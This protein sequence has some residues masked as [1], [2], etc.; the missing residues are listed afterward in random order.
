MTKSHNEV[1]KILKEKGFNLNEQDIETIRSEYP[2]FSLEELE[3]IGY[4]EEIIAQIQIIPK[5][6]VKI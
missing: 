1:L 2:F 3:N 6:D 4:I 5:E